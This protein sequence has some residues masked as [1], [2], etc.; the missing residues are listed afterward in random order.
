MNKLLKKEEF[1]L[2]EFINRI[3]K[4]DFSGSEG[5]EIK[6]SFFMMLTSFATRIGSLIFTIIIARLLMP[7]LFGLYSIVLA[8]IMVFALFSDLEIGSAF[9]RFISKEL[10]R[11]KKAKAKAYAVY[12]L[13]IKIFLVFASMITLILVSRYLANN[14]FEKPLFLGFIAGALYLILLGISEI[15]EDIMFSSN[16]FK[17]IFWKETLFQVIRVIIV[18]VLIILGLK[19]SLSNEIN[20][21]LIIIGLTGSLLFATTIIYFFSRE[22]FDFLRHKEEKLTESENKKINKF[23]IAMPSIAISGLFFGEIDILFLGHFV[24]ADF[25]GYYRAVFGLVGGIIALITFSAALLPVFS[26]LGKRE[27]ERDFNKF[28]GVTILLSLISVILLIIFSPL[29]I[30]II[31]GS[32]YAVSSGILRIFSIVII[33]NPIISLYETYFISRGKPRMISKILILSTILNVILTYTFIKTFLVNGQLFAVYGAIIASII[34]RYVIMFS[35]IFY[36]RRL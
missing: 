33:S 19:Y 4:K 5:L 8:V 23:M 34:S 18:P 2:K 26:K 16:S 22:K 3:R 12:F 29:I 24:L 9:V 25:V 35:L 31:Y 20:I 32:S 11:N 13:K 27:I 21:S 7:E 10:G 6:N 15:L 1:I 36:K 30:N 14:I 28:L 17:N